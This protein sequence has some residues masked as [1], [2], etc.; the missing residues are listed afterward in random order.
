MTRPEYVEYGGMTNAPGPLD[1]E[2]ARLWS[3]WARA[4]RGRLRALCR[5][6]F[7]EPTGGAVDAHPLFG[8]VQITFGEIAR[9]T[10]GSPYDRRGHVTERQV[11]IWLPVLVLRR[12]ALPFIGSAIPY[13]WLEDPLS[14]ASGRENYGYPKNWGWTLLPGEAQEPEVLALDTY[15]IEHYDPASKPARRRLLEVRPAEGEQSPEG[16]GPRGESYET[17]DGMLRAAFAALS[18]HDLAAPRGRAGE[19]EL[20]G[21]EGSDGEAAVPVPAEALADLSRS[22]INQVFLKQFRSARDVPE[23][24]LLQVTKVPAAV[25]AFHGSRKL[26]GHDLTVHA[27]D[28][29]PLGAELGL[30]DSR[31]LFGTEAR[32]DFTIEAGTVIWSSGGEP[33]G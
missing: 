10:P 19:L 27:V 9:I 24:A 1:C 28:S 5:R 14:V 23:A 26:R 8:A 15:G 4:D 21:G 6:M 33:A 18:E 31:L 2:G 25:T 30:G 16:A 29:H 22:T 17:F 12:G 11:G 3:F 13:M 20:P 7:T 32:F